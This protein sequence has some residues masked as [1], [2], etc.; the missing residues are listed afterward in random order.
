MFQSKQNRVS[1]LWLY[2]PRSIKK[3]EKKDNNTDHELNEI[4]VLWRKMFLNV[5]MKPHLNVILLFKNSATNTEDDQKVGRG[6]M[7]SCEIVS[8]TRCVVL[9]PPK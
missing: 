7:Y 2:E 1:F 6:W 8:D 4:L 9:L 3:K 5:K